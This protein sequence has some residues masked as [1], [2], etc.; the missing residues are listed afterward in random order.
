[1]GPRRGDDVRAV[2]GAE[3]FLRALHG[4]YSGLLWAV[5]WRSTGDHGRAQDAVQEVL[6]RAWRHPEVFDPD[7]GSPRAW[8]LA[9][10]RH[11]LVDEWRARH[12]RPEVLTDAPPERVTADGVDAALRSLLVTEALRRLSVEHRAV[13]VECYYRGRSVSEAAAHLG[14]PPGTVKS[15]THYALRAL[16]VVLDEMEVAR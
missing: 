15:R 10:L 2:E 12:V 14:V 16:R 6:L 4:E 1:V 8:L 5:A 11:V 9:T 3:G 13:L 7:R